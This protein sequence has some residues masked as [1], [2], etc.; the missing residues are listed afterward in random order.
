[1]RIIPVGL[2]GQ[3]K[4]ILT[5]QYDVSSYISALSDYV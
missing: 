2:Q 1:M 5:I 4:D 3:D